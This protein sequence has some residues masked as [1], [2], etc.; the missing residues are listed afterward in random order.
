MKDINIYFVIKVNIKMT[1][2]Y[3]KRYSNHQPSVKC[4]LVKEV[5][6]G[7]LSGEI[8]IKTIKIPNS[9]K[10]AVKLNL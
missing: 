3:M 9:N 5:R 2:E 6:L 10:D 8:K 7:Y 4:K 1:N